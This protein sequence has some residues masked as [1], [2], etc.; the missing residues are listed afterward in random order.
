MGGLVDADHAI[1]TS[2]LGVDLDDACRRES[3]AL[4]G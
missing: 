4:L 3:G 2:R 1:A